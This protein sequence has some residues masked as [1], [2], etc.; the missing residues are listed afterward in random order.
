M[1]TVQRVDDLP[2]GSGLHIT[3]AKWLTPKG[4]WVHDKGLKSDVEVKLTEDDIKNNKD[5]QLE[6]AKELLR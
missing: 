6:K 2:D 4:I 3:F 1:G 5:P